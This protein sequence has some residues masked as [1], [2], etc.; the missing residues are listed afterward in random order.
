LADGY[1]ALDTVKVK[2]YKSHNQNGDVVVGTEVPA[3][4]G[5]YDGT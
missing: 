2:N 4:V 3:D 5:H 1:L